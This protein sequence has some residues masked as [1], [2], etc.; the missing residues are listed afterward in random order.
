M[1]SA[2]F[3]GIIIGAIAGGLCFFV[4][5]LMRAV[6]AAGFSMVIILSKLKGRAIKQS[7]VVR[8]IIVAGILVFTVLG[9]LASVVL[10]GVVGGAVQYALMEMS[11]N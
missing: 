1:A 11:R 6:Y 7:P 9:L 4:F 10:G 5:G 2:H 8:I 3:I